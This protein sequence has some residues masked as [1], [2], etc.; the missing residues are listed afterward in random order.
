MARLHVPEAFEAGR[1]RWPDVRLPLEDFAQRLEAAD[2][3]SGDLSCRGADLYLAAA[4]AAGDRAAIRHFDT[5]FVSTV[6]GRVARFGLSADKMD[7]LR[8]KIRTKLLMGPS[9]GIGGYRGRAPLGAWVHVTAVR[10][11]VD[12]AS[13]GY[14][15]SLNVDLMELVAPEQNP[16]IETARRLYEERFRMALEEIFQEL[17]TR[18]KTILRLHVVDGL[19]IDAIGA[20]YRVHR[21]TAAR[22]LVGIRA[23]VYDRLKKDFA[24]RWK[25]SSSDLRSLVSLLRDHIHI[26]ATRVLGSA[27]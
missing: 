8:Q 23:K 21:A 27:S 20:I 18:E 1:A 4:C 22:W 17:P 7:D 11:A 25:A 14:A 5:M 12:L 2:V 9:P 16:E 19:N 6:D 15:P 13:P 3:E 24:M 26:T 10:V